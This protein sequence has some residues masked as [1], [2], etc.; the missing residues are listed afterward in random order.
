[1]MVSALVPAVLYRL[2]YFYRW[3]YRFSFYFLSVL[4]LRT[5][6]TRRKRS[7]QN[8]QAVVT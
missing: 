2:H 5:L 3:F 7:S 4:S 6:I 1:M 8:E